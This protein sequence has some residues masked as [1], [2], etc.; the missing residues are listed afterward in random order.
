MIHGT[1]DDFV[2]CEMTKQGFDACTSQKELLL[3][4]NA[5]H[6]TS[7]LVDKEAYIKT[8]IAFLEKHLED[9]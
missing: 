2:P 4:E 3:I 9:F 7:F 1:A 8:V 6:G 5:G